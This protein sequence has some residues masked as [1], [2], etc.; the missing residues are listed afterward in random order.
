MIVTLNGPEQLHN[1]LR[2]YS[3]YNGSSPFRDTLAGI[4]RIRK[5]LCEN[6]F[7]T[8]VSFLANYANA[9]EFARIIKWYQERNI[10][11]VGYFRSLCRLILEYKKGSVIYHL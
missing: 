8:R 3:G 7:A 11:N 6:D 4:E 2:L 9:G 1:R 5:R 10:S